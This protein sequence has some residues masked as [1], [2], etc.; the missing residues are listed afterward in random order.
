M[1]CIRCTTVRQ[2]WV[3]YTTGELVGRSYVYPDGYSFDEFE[4]VPTRQ[5]FR[6]MLFAEHLH[7]QRQT[8]RLRSV[9]RSA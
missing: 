8:R 6:Q 7:E 2:D 4:G 9:G 5:D 3:Y 1:R